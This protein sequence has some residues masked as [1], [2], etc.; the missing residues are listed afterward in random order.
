MVGIL[1]IN[2][3]WFMQEVHSNPLIPDFVQIWITLFL[4]TITNTSVTTSSNDKKNSSI[5]QSE[6]KP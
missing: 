6:T 4:L 2:Q 1:L 5:R 3:D